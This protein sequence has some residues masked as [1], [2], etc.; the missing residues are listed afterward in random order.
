MINGRISANENIDLG[1]GFTLTSNISKDLDF[2]LSTN[3]TYSIVNSSLQ[4]NANN[5]YFIQN[6]NI[7][8]YYSPNEG[9]LFVSNNV[10]HMLYSG[11]SEG[12]DQSVWLWNVEAGYRFLKNNKGELKLTI[13]DLLGQNNS[14]SRS[15][16]DVTITDTYT[17]VL[18]RYG[19]VS[20]TYII[21]SFKKSEPS[22]DEPSF[23]RGMPPRGGGRS[24]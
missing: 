15:I 16:S 21:G 8:F 9:K 18:T 6:S 14:I 19:L 11:L 2:T 10:N 3:G 23:R 13:F 24:W 17:N 22:S 4:T 12:M 7:R 1:Q 20:F 5:N